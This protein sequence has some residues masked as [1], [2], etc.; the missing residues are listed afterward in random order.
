MQNKYWRTTVYFRAV[1]RSCDRPY[2]IYAAHLTASSERECALQVLALG[3]VLSCLLIINALYY[4]SVYLDDTS[5]SH[6]SSGSAPRAMLPVV[7]SYEYRLQTRLVR[8]AS[9][10]VY[11]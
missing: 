3:L 2:D 1:R 6:G 5:E 9:D 10:S 8:V 7:F 11:R 4:G